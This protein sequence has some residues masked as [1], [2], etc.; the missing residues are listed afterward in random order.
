MTP[1][2]TGPDGMT[3]AHR[4]GTEPSA[5]GTRP[6]AEPPSVGGAGRPGSNVV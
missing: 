4:L 3:L 2:T 5:W 1:F 6:G